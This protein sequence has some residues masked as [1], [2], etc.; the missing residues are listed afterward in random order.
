VTETVFVGGSDNL[1]AS[2]VERL[3][4]R[5]L[6]VALDDFGTGYA[7]LVHLKQFPV[8]VLKID[9]SFVEQF[10]KDGGDPVVRAIIGLG[11]G[12]RITT[13]AEGIETE[14]Q[15]ARLREEG[16]DQGQGF[17]V[18]AAVPAEQVP[19]LITDI[20]IHAAKD[21]RTRIRRHVDKIAA[22]RR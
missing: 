10:T 14:L 18:S 20:G 2:S 11:K 21:R 8:N 17:L 16:C 9:R 22:L 5:G 6:R 3:R 7:S 15:A 19:A 12:L 4:S 1:V 13:I